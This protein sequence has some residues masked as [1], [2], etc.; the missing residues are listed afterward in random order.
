MRGLN[1]AVHVFG[2]GF[3]YPAPDLAIRG[4]DAVKQSPI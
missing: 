2:G 4:I 3:R 1:R